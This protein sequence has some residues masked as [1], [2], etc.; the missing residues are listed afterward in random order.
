M[1]SGGD[2]SR[3][4]LRFLAPRQPRVLLVV[5]IAMMLAPPGAQADG[6]PASDVLLLRN[7]FFL[8]NPPPTAALQQKLNAEVAAAGRAGVPIKVA[9]IRAPLDLGLVPE[10]FARPQQY[11]DFLGQ[12][13][14]NRYA[15]PLLVVMPNGY[16][17]HGVNAAARSAVGR[18]P[19][20]MSG[21]IDDL[22]RAAS[23]AVATIASASGHPISTPGTGGSSSPVVAI[24]AGVVVLIAATAA[25][26]LLIR[27]RASTRGSS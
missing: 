4:R 9:L 12:E 13:I 10:L 15:G 14:S 3:T 17:V 23:T 2:E 18:L 11:A 20:P 1:L 7:V 24:L 27:R 26:L 6:D 5:L 19:R 8:Y 25:A 22:A 21:Q 16:G